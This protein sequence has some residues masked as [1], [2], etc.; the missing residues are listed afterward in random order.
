[1]N[2]CLNCGKQTK[3][4]KYCSRTCA[5]VHKWKNPEY[6]DKQRKINKDRWLDEDRRNRVS[7]KMKE[8][9]KNNKKRREILATI[10]KKRWEDPSN[11]EKHSECMKD[12]WNDAEYKE[13]TSNAIAQSL[14]C[15]HIR[16]VKSKN[17]KKFWTVDNRK[18][19]SDYMKNKWDDDEYKKEQSEKQRIIQNSPE[20]KQKQIDHWRNSNYA[21][22]NICHHYKYK[23]FVLPSGKCIKLQGNEPLVLNELLNYFDET[24]IISGIKNIEKEIGIIEYTNDACIHRYHPD[25]YIKSIHTIVEVKSSWTFKIQRS[26]NMLKEQA[27]KDAGLHFKFI[28]VDNLSEAKEAC[29]IF[30]DDK[31]MNAND[32]FYDEI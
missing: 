31:N 26:K 10:N 11:R 8:E 23:K 4:K 20:V 15:D 9:W 30:I 14:D 24:D 5:N 13:K 3:N 27:C 25:F 6:V 18:K 16:K 32:Y 28:I 12:K 2:I 29:K 7:N 1:M 22:K 17:S 19:H 21:E